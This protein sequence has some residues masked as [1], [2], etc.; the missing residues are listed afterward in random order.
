MLFQKHEYEYGVFH[1][2][3]IFSNYSP[4]M[5]FGLVDDAVKAGCK[6][7]CEVADYIHDRHSNGEARKI[8]SEKQYY[9][10][11]ENAGTE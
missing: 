3:H 9:N 4:D 5:T 2:L 1:L 7:G 11:K 10:R 6:T 8:Y